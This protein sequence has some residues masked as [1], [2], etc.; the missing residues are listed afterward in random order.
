MSLLNNFFFAGYMELE[1]N[2]P[3]SLSFCHYFFFLHKMREIIISFFGL[4]VMVL[5]DYD[6]VK[7]K[8]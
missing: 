7:F 5:H 4:L 6:P 8:E 2:A 1:Q 3:F